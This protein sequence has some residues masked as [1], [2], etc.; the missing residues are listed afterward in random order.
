MKTF[1]PLKNLK[2]KMNLGGKRSSSSK[3]AAIVDDDSTVALS[4]DGGS[5]HTLSTMR[6][7][8]RRSKSLFSVSFDEQVAMF[9]LDDDD[10]QSVVAPEDIWY[11]PEEMAEMKEATQFSIKVARSSEA[12]CAP[13]TALHEAAAKKEKTPPAEQDA[14]VAALQY[15]LR[16]QPARVGLEG[17]MN[18]SFTA[19]RRDALVTLIHNFDRDHQHLNANDLAEQLAQAC[20]TVTA[21]AV[22]VATQVARAV[23]E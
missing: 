7:S 21:P 3:A 13:L 4:L 12:F 6:S 20:R 18:K 15:V 1:S 11:S 8:S 10:D 9:C 5:S 23:A 16:L 17:R 2:N 22:C 14:H 19:Q